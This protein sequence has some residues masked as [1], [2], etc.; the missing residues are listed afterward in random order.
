MKMYRSRE[1]KILGVCQGLA[2]FTGFSVKYFRI[3]AVIVAILTGGWAVLVYLVAALL[4]PVERPE[5]YESK[6]FKEN[7]EDF[8]D[9][10]GDFA[11][12]EFRDLKEA[13]ASMRSVRRERKAAKKEPK[14]DLNKG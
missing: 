13:G 7:F 12:K 9:D 8:R 1:G 10:A 11:K 4:I 2:D 3:A 14:V 6:G 5:G